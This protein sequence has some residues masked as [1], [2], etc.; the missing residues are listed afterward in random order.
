M[1][2]IAA[3]PPASRPPGPRG[4]WLMGNLPELRPDRLAALTRWAREYGDIV[5]VRLAHRRIWALNHPDLI[6]EVLVTKNRCFTKHFALKTARPTL[7]E[8]LLTSEGD[9][10]RRQ[11]KLS[12]PAFHRERVASYAEVMVRY[13][14]EL[15]A[16]WPDG[17]ALDIHE[18]MMLVTLRIVAKTLFD[19]DVG[20][21]AVGVSHAMEILMQ[22]FTAR[23]NRFI[24]LPDFL[25][26]PSNR[27]HQKALASLEAI[28]FRIIADRRAGGIDRGDLL[29]MLLQAQDDDDGTG[30]TD[31]QLRDEA[32]TLFLAGHETTANTLAWALFLLADHPEVEAKLHE[33]IDRVLDGRPP[34]FADLPQL[35]YTDRVITETLR[36]YPTV[37]LL[38]R[39]AVEPVEI[40]G[41]ACQGG[42]RCG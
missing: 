36:I 31:R 17:G 1:A 37:W 34:T 29:S 24:R 42:P 38:G 14:E 25:P 26:T 33:E 2:T 19:A 21:D 7:G 9:F 35:A 18:E 12:Q 41:L 20:G 8:G 28:L 39:E 5:S 11:R 13:A 10:W 16:R 27:R 4:H 30:M 6:E 40:G 3:R 22:T 32:M 23:I 15:I